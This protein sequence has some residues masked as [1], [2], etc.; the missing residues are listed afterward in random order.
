MNYVSVILVAV[1][2]FAVGY[3]YI[4]GRNY[5]IGPRVK[6][7]LIDGQE[8]GDGEFGEGMA[9][10]ALEELDAEK[11]KSSPK[12]GSNSSREVQV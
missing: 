4:A 8:A 1:F 2:L 5:Y 11:K 9:K 10:E 12:D 7:Q 3:W 6:A